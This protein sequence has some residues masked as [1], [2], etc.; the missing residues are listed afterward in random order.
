[1]NETRTPR[2]EHRHQQWLD[3]RLDAAV[4]A[5][6]ATEPALPADRIAFHREML[7]TQITDS[8]PAT[9]VVDTGAPVDIHASARRRRRL[10]LAGA[11]AAS[12]GALVAGPAAAALVNNF[13]HRAPQSVQEADKMEVIY[14]GQSYTWAQIYALQAKG[15]ATISVEEPTTYNQGQAYVFDTAAEA[16]AWACAHV[17]GLVP[18]SQRQLA[19]AD[20]NSQ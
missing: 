18:D 4:T 5:L 17:A 13:I 7:M 3:E 11:S 19:V 2:E 9:E 20:R 6:R 12:I 14:Q 8:A 1:M 16:D 15:K 10:M